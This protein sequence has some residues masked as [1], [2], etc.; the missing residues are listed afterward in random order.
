MGSLSTGDEATGT[1]VPPVWGPDPWRRYEF[2]WWDGTGWTEHVRNGTNTAI[3]PPPASTYA[4]AGLQGVAPAYERAWSGAVPAHLSFFGAVSR[5][6]RN[7]VNFKDRAA[8]SEYWWFFLFYVLVVFGLALLEAV[9]F[10]SYTAVPALLAILAMF[11]PILAVTV[12]RLHDTGKSGW[13]I[14]VGYIP[15]VGS[16]LMIVWTVTPSYPRPNRWGPPPQ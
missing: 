4:D 13:M 16:I 11:L 6:F 7:Y 1:A 3:D 2:R 8:P 5:C 15:I 10:R 14:L 9:L 12:R